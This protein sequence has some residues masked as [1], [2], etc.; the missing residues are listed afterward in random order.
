MFFYD[1]QLVLPV[2]VRAGLLP[3]PDRTVAARVSADT[4]R[5]AE[6]LPVLLAANDIYG[7]VRLGHFW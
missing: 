4:V 6:L 2:G 1:F 7:G 5:D 3:V